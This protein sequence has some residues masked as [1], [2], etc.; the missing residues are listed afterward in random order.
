M[1]QANTNT[2]SD[3]SAHAGEVAVYV[4]SLARELKTMADGHKLTALGYLLG[5]VRAEA[6]EQARAESDR[7]A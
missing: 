1:Q 6:E 7:V 2:G 3:E 5:L 4:A